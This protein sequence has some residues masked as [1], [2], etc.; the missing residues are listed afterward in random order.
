MTRRRSHKNETDLINLTPLLD[1]LF[2]V[3]VMFILI[4]PLIQTDNI[5]LTKAPKECSQAGSK[6]HQG[7]K[8]L[9]DNN[10]DIWVQ[11]K[12]LTYRELQLI[13]SKLTHHKTLQLYCDKR[14]SFGT[15]QRIKMMMQEAGFSELQVVLEHE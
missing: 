1:V 15:F 12:K 9:V 13:A 7:L 14:A 8:I 2:V 4:T 11:K 6:E 10:N 5:E 3:L